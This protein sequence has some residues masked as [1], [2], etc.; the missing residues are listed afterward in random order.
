MSRSTTTVKQENALVR[1]F[2]DTRAEIG[3]VTWPTREEGMRLTWVVFIVT[4]IS[5][6]VLFGVDSLFGLIVAFWLQIT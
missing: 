5:A 2:K 1:Y 3:K 4:A 6:V